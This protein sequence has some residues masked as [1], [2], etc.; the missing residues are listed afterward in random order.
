MQEGTGLSDTR[1]GGRGFAFCGSTS[2]ASKKAN[3][4]IGFLR[5]SRVAGLARQSCQLTKWD[6]SQ[7]Y[8]VGENHQREPARRT[9]RAAPLR[10][11]AERKASPTSAPT[12]VAS[13]AY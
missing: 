6:L 2:R 13:P 8:T 11:A 5:R 1:A 3:E 7:H 12:V 4:D 9:P 10:F